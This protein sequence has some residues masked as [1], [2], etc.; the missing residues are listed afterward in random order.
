[1]ESNNLDNSE[2]RR[3]INK[4]FKDHGFPLLSESLTY[5]TGQ[6]KDMKKE[7]Y[8]KTIS[9]LLELLMREN[10]LFFFGKFLNNEKKFSSSWSIIAFGYFEE[11]ANDFSKKTK[12]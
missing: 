11:Y 2:F 10:S 9:R 12:K 4:R 1:M 8:E 6:L 7:Q 5:L 3:H